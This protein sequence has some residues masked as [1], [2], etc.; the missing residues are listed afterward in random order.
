LAPMAGGVESRWLTPR[1][2]ASVAGLALVASGLVL[3]A[4]HDGVPV[5]G[6]DAIYAGVARSVAAGHGLDVPIHYYPLGNVSIGTPPPGSSAPRPTPLVVYAP[7]QPVLEAIGGQHPIGTARVEDAVFLALVVLIAGLFVLYVTDELWLAAGAQLIIGLSL[8]A[9]VGSGGTEASALF[10]AIVGLVAVLR[11]RE[12]PRLPWLILG[13]AAFGLATVT[14]FAAGGLVIWGVLALRRRRG[15]ALGLLVMSSLPLAGWFIYEKVSGRS[16]G[17]ALGFHVVK[18]TV[19][20]GF[21]TIAFW[22]LPATISLALAVV[23]TLVVT[24]IVALVLKRRTGSVPCALVLYAIIQIVV[25]EV[26]ITFFDAGV[27][28]EPREFIPIFVAVV[29]AVACGVAR[30]KPVMIVTLL[31][32][33]G[34]A[35]RFGIDTATSPPGDYTTPRWQHSAILADVKALPAHSIIYSDAPDWIYMLAGRAT[36]TVPETMDF[37]TLKQNIRFSAQIREI[38][39]TLTARGGYVVY[40][41]TLGRESFLPSEA[42][43]RKLLSLHLVDNSRYGAIYT[44]GG[45]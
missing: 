28:L 32:V 16:T 24:G 26:A 42:T 29:I 5:A 17:H 25:L 2:L 8:A 13:S 43:L 45:R 34:C 37:S 33:I 27:D 15:A 9:Q 6:D 40:I 41:R 3:L 23:G 31:L 19:R 35:L 11:Y 18:T 22:I 20:S 39:E 30:T 1:R 10:F 38:R 21:H 7:L 4:T 12:H 36:S 44:I 14:R